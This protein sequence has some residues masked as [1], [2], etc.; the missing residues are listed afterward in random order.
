MLCCSNGTAFPDRS[1]EVDPELRRS[2]ANRGLFDLC[3]LPDYLPDDERRVDNGTS[4]PPF[5]DVQLRVEGEVAAVLGELAR[6]RWRRATGKKIKP[7]RD[8]RK[9]PG[10][11]D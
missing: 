4:Y 6:Q 3:A 8:D 11:G 9:E 7:A 5:H 1:H 2:R 10:A